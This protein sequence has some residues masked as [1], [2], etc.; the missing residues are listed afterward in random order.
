MQHAPDTETVLQLCRDNPQQGLGDLM[1]R[2]PGHEEHVA[3]MWFAVHGDE[4]QRQEEPRH[5]A[6]GPYELLQALGTGS[7]GE[8]FLARD[9]RTGR[10]VA[11]K[12]LHGV[13]SRHARERLQNEARALARLRHPAIAEVLDAEF[14]G[15]VP[16]LAVR[17]VEGQ[18]LRDARGTRHGPFASADG[19]FPQAALRWFEQVARAVHA[20]HE[21]GVVHADLHP[22]NLIVTPTGEAVVLDFGTARV[23]GAVTITRTGMALGSA[24]HAAPEVLGGARATRASDIYSIASVLLTCACP[25]DTAPD[26]AHILS[27]ELRLLLQR[28]M[29]GRPHERFPS[30]LA[31]A[32]ELRRLRAG[33]PILT[34]TPSKMARAMRALA[35]NPWPLVAAA[36]LSLTL[37]GVGMSLVDLWRQQKRQHAAAAHGRRLLMELVSASEANDAATRQRATAVDAGVGQ[38]ESQAGFEL[39]VARLL[40]R[41][42]DLAATGSHLARAMQSTVLADAV[43]V[44]AALVALDRG[45]PIAPGAGDGSPLASFVDGLAKWQRGDIA[46]GLSQAA[47]AATNAAWPDAD[48]R[49]EARAIACWL[50]IDDGE[51]AAARAVLAELTPTAAGPNRTV[52]TLLQA[53]LTNDAPAT[54]VR[55]LR[56]AWA[57]LHQQLGSEH[58]WTLRA[59]RA[60][61]GALAADAQ[62]RAAIHT[63]QDLAR[64]QAR[65]HGPAHVEVIASLSCEHEARVGAAGRDAGADVRRALANM[66]PSPARTRALRAASVV[67]AN[68]FVARKPVA[69]ARHVTDCEAALLAAR[70][71]T[72]E[73][74]AEVEHLPVAEH[75]A[76]ARR[77]RAHIENV[78]WPLQRSYTLLHVARGSRE[79]LARLSNRAEE[80]FSA[81]DFERGVRAARTALA[82]AKTAPGADAIGQLQAEAIWHKAVIE[83]R[84]RSDQDPRPLVAALQRVVDTMLVHMG[85]NDRTYAATAKWLAD[86]LSRLGGEDDLRRA[87]PLYI[88]VSRAQPLEA[89]HCWWVADCAL[90]LRDR[91]LATKW[92]EDGR[93]LLGPRPDGPADWRWQ[94]FDKLNAQLRQLD[95]GSEKIGR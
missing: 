74:W 94:Y 81:G 38:Q 21:A 44:E 29:A 72:A 12:R 32:E 56:D 90:R 8:V 3:R 24:R 45:E 27:P 70:A 48:V 28:A 71:R 63:S 89:V 79:F 57:Q 78:E 85:P 60:V 54:A 49:D 22:G 19:S 4:H 92:L 37:L 16:F 87:I 7:Q 17:Y 76:F 95:A 83:Q 65:V 26:F 36:A 61:A 88:V 93:T 52:A 66:P 15:A 41:V 73:L 40:R 46:A 91:A 10:R 6:I 64:R 42:G 2:F 9:R 80:L 51:L 5:D 39:V 20:A 77:V 23:E 47:A 25:A 68:H 86:V 33:E 69:R 35:H 31:F 43:R 14:D 30:A 82:V 34:G 84:L 55:R 62:W 13:P 50:A 58:P 59:E 53:R 11:C 67:E 1:V 75:E 18:A